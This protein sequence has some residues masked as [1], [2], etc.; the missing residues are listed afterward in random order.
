MNTFAESGSLT[1]TLLLALLKQSI[2]PIPGPS[3]LLSSTF[4]LLRDI[5]LSTCQGNTARKEMERPTE[6]RGGNDLPVCLDD[7]ALA[8]ET[9]SQK[10]DSAGIS[11]LH[12]NFGK[13]Y[14][15]HTRDSALGCICLDTSLRSRQVEMVG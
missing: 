4:S 2:C 13:S 10:L 14:A 1:H 12:A 3:P 9:N 6:G 7:L 5:L 15:N 11:Q 8:L